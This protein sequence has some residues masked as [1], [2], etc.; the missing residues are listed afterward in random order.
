MISFFIFFNVVES[1]SDKAN[2]F[3][4]HFRPIGTPVNELPANVYYNGEFIVVDVSAIQTPTVIQIYDLLGRTILNKNVE[5]NTIHY[6]PVYNKELV[7]IVKMNSN[8]MQLT[9]KIVIY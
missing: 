7:Y 6:L 9:K 5:G 2:R 4:I 8:G 1:V 3:V